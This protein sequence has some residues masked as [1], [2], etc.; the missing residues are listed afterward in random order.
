MGYLVKKEVYV[1]LLL[2]LHPAL[3]V[4]FHCFPVQNYPKLRKYH[5]NQVP[6]KHHKIEILGAEGAS[7]ILLEYLISEIELI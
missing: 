3:V 2:A 4:S 5:E 6:H 1:Q 7:V